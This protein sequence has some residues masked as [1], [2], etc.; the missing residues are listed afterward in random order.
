MVAHVASKTNQNFQT[1]GALIMQVA[2]LLRPKLQEQLRGAI[3][4]N[5]MAVESA[6][7]RGMALIIAQEMVKNAKKKFEN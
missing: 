3:D 1:T 7:V 2:D 5:G 6:R 4:E